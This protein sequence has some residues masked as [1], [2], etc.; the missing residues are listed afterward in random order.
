MDKITKEEATKI[1]KDIWFNI[2]VLERDYG[3]EYEG[4]MTNILKFTIECIANKYSIDLKLRK[5]K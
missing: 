5:E 3:I 1:L 2:C 4:Y